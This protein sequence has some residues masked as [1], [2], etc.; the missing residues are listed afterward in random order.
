MSTLSHRASQVGLVLIFL[1]ALIPFTPFKV[2][3]AY[4]SYVYARNLATGHGL[5]YNG[6]TVEGYSNPLWT[7]LLSPFISFGVDP[8]IVARAFSIIS[9]AI[10]L[11]LVFKLCALLIDKPGY[12][13]P[14]IATANAA[15]LSP[16]AA[17]SM[18]G[19]ETVFLSL[20][21]VLL[22]YNEWDEGP[23]DK[24]TSPLILL[25]IALTRPEGLMLFP[26]WLLYRLSRTDKRKQTALEAVV[27]L[28]PFSLFLLWRWM[29]Y[30]YLLPNTAYLK[31]GPTLEDSVEAGIWLFRFLGLRP[32]F[33]FLLVIG[34]AVSLIRKSIAKHSLVFILGIISGF[35][36]FVIFSGRDWMPHHRYIAPVAPLMALFIAVALDAIGK[37]KFRMGMAVIAVIAIGAEVLLANT[38]YKP[39][40]D[41]F[42]RF[43]DGLIEAGKWIN[44]NTS[45]SATI[46]VVD[47]GAIA[48]YAERATVDI[49][50]LND[51]HIAHSS[52]KSDS[53]Y[54]LAYQPE[55]IQLHAEYT[56]TGELL[57]TPR[58]IPTQEILD[59]QVFRKCYLPDQARPP[60]PYYPFLFLRTCN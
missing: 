37:I 3:D 43:T 9:G 34:I 15:V 52:T 39:V 55:V 1:L 11:L 36:A 38:I 4:I 22:I 57:P 40:S 2:D 14:F 24:W 56:Q 48:Y 23:A 26:I 51:V 31:L 21:L 32:A 16:F 18:G 7:V 28:V 44:Q 20:L 30:G 59:H 13:L 6:I 5:T 54:V 33:A 19:L 25:A 46:A 41:D 50:G 49:L 35:V 27:F 45:L 17:W 58:G 42:G 53:D 8:L 10:A 47:A 29:T 60:G 12:L